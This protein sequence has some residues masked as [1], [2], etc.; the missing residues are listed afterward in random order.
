MLRKLWNLFIAFTRASNLGF[1]GGPALIPLIRVE[2]VDRYQW[3]DNQEFADSIAICNAL[4]GPI[5][6]KLAAFIGYKIAGWMGAAVAII[7]AVSPTLIIVVLLGSL[8]MKYSNS[9]EFKAMIEAVRPV[10]VVLVAEAAYD[11]GK[12]AFPTGSSWAI[13]VITIAVLFLTNIHPAIIILAAMLI[14]W[15]LYGRI[16]NESSQ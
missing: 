11:M 5:A 2:A 4:P 13:A 3:L 9:L 7:G 12:D 16:K 1:G 6:T 14:G 15:V 10:V 8:T